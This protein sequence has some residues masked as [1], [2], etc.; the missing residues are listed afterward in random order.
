[1][2]QNYSSTDLNNSLQVYLWGSG[3]FYGIYG[4]S[5]YS[6]SNGIVAT[7]IS[8]DIIRKMCVGT[9]DV[10]VIPDG[11]NFITKMDQWII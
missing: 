9:E 6:F 2:V 8:V 4:L 3:L 10:R 11:V 7:Y 5:V 1:M